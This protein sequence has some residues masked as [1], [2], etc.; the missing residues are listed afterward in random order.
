MN[1]VRVKILISQIHELP[2][3]RHLIV[4]VSVSFAVQLYKEYLKS[5]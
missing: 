4:G 3:D 2:K 5:G 1:D